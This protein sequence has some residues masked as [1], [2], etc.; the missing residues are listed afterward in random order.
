[1][2]GAEIAGEHERENERQSD[3]R[4]HYTFHTAAEPE[5]ID[6]SFLQDINQMSSCDGNG[7][8]LQ[9]VSVVSEF[10]TQCEIAHRPVKVERVTKTFQKGML[11]TTLLSPLYNRAT[12]TEILSCNGFT[13]HCP[14]ISTVGRSRRATHEI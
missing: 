7:L 6:L 11:R 5:S 8:A 2:R 10:K 9:M 4:C 13:L 1:M 14:E 3:K 12:C